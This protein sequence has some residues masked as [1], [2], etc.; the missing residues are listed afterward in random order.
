MN[1]PNPNTPTPPDPSGA[2][3]EPGTPTPPSEPPAAPEWVG[4]LSD[5]LKGNEDLARFQSVE[6]LAKAYVGRPAAPPV[7][8]AGEY[9]LPENFPLKDFGEFAS[10]AGLTQD[11][12][13]KLLEYN[14][15]TTED[16]TKVYR[17]AMGQELNKLLDQWGD[18]KEPNTSLARRALKSFDTTDGQLKNFLKVTNS[19]EHPAV[20]NFFYNLGKLLE[21]TPYLK[22]ETTTPR[23]KKESS[24]V[25]YPDQGA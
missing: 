15:R 3:G 2:P 8:K 9:Q 5:E 16:Q 25:L 12:V 20:V 10:D 4:T 7:P 6:D 11:Q 21:E 24:E 22:T 19:H 17:E 13:S 23:K 1:E 14:K 18:Q